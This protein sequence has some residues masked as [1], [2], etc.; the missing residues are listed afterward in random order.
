M[1]SEENAEESTTTDGASQLEQIREIVKK[2]IVEMRGAGLLAYSQGGF[3]DGGDFEVHLWRNDAAKSLH[4]GPYVVTI[5][6]SNRNQ[7]KKRPSNS[8]RRGRIDLTQF[9]NME[10]NRPWSA[11]WYPAEEEVEPDFLIEGGAE[12]YKV[13]I[14]NTQGGVTLAYIANGN[15]VLAKQIAKLPDLIA[16]LKKMYARE[17]ELLE[18]LQVIKEDLETGIAQGNIPINATTGIDLTKIRN[19]ANDAS[20]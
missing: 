6:G 9:E 3:G 17:D 16:E 18:A 2:A 5:K 8:A 20:Q 14:V 19:F 11:S 15:E 12:G 1:D 4:G 13:R 10:D 7:S